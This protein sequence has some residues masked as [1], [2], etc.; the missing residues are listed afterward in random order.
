M[1]LFKSRKNIRLYGDCNGEFTGI[2]IIVGLAPGQRWKGE[3]KEH[4]WY[5]TRKNSG[6]CLRL[7]DAALNRFFE[8]VIY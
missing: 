6:C 3:K 5:L 8:E 1:K 7:T 4:Y 2:K